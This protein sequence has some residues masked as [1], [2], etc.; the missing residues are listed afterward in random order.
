MSKQINPYLDFV[1][2]LDATQFDLL[3][4]SIKHR[5]DRE[6][7]GSTS[8]EE[9]VLYY[10]RKPI[11][12]KCHSDKYHEDGYTSS[13]AKR[14]RCEN[15]ECSYTLLSDSIF[16]S[17]KISFHKLMSYIPIFDTKI[18]KNGGFLR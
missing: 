3:C 18:I 7:Y 1:L 15:C 2:G 12:P 4:D 10:G 13:L 8:F 17:S 9:A 16:N 5:K 6:R 11:C 14:Y